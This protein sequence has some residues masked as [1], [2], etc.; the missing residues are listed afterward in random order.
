MERDQVLFDYLPPPYRGQEQL[1]MTSFFPT[2]DG[3]HRAARRVA[4]GVGRVIE[5]PTAQ[6]WLTYL[7]DA[8][9]AA[10]VL[11]PTS[12]LGYGLIA[13][14]DWAAGLARAYND[15]VFDQFAR[16][17]PTRIKAV[18]LIPLQ[19]PARAAK[20]LE[21]A[22]TEQ[23]YVGAFFPAVGLWEAFGHQSFWP[24]Y[25]VAQALDVPVL[26]HGGPASGIGVDR[27]HRA[28]EMRSLN[29]V[30]S[31]LVQMTSMVFGGVYD[32]FPRLRVAY[33]EAGCGW[34]AYLLERLDREYSSRYTQV[35]HVKVKPSEHLRSGRV[36][37]HT[38][39]EE[40]G[41]ANAIRAFG[42]DAFI[43][44]SDYPHEPKEEFPVVFEEFE[45]RTDIPDSA[46]RKVLWDNPIR[47][48]NLNEAEISAVLERRVTAASS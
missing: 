37:I 23:G 48:F 41:L 15:W 45:E 7:D 30:M 22:V 18:A 19:D 25:E 36:F 5:T 2:L 44:A 11:F 3:F 32:A 38:E 10:T 26:V 16:V 13:D 9:L 6:D 20:E 28:I 43:C 47:L 40:E 8:E 39:L 33:L 4:D 27:L 17:N 21:R 1:F 24:V 34:T 35:P 12:G 14:A 42:E 46:K 31:Q 29:H